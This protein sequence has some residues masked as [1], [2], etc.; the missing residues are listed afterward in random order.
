MI[1]FRRKTSLLTI[2]E[3]HD[4]TLLTF[5]PFVMER[6]AYDLHT[7]ELF[8]SPILMIESSWQE[9]KLRALKMTFHVN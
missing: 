3:S 5:R 2:V 7:L 8:T 6:F 4:R 9:R 1:L